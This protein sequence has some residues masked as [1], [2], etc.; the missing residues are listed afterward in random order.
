MI[1]KVELH[2]PGGSCILDF[3]AG[4][5]ELGGTVVNPKI[6]PQ[7]WLLLEGMLESRHYMLTYENI[8]ELLWG[9]PLIN[10]DFPKR[11]TVAVSRVN[12]AFE[13]LCGLPLLECNADSR[14]Y[15]I[16]RSVT[17]ETP[18]ET[19]RSGTLPHLLTRTSVAFEDEESMLHRNTELGQYQDLCSGKKKAVL[20]S[21][22][23]G[24]GK[25]TLA[26]ALFHKLAPDFD[27]V[28]WVEYHGDLQES[29]LASF[30]LCDDVADSEHRWRA[31]EEAMDGSGGRKLLVVDNVDLS[32]QRHQYPQDDRYLQQVSGW[33][34]T[35]VILTSRSDCIAGF[36]TCLVEMLGD[37]QHPEPCMDL[38]YYYYD[39]KEMK[40]PME[41]RWQIDAVRYLVEL[42]R[43]H[44]YTIELLARSAQYEDDLAEYARTIEAKGFGVSTLAVGTGRSGEKHTTAEQLRILFDPDSRPEKEQQILWDFSVLPE[45]LSLSRQ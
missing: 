20:L 37:K 11:I 2:Y 28:G 1:N 36:Q 27:S 5:V 15:R 14:G 19:H 44:T 3:P 16:V 41:E 9:D 8:G 45:N 38:F 25:T 42:G 43:Y 40:K 24:V 23:G 4:T 21:G 7:G 31:I 12:K 35:T 22:F 30:T 6:G 13:D 29:I 32:E 26:R 34:N 17:C 39:Q 33:Q 18:K 10:L